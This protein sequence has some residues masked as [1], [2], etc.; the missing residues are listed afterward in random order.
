MRDLFNCRARR[1]LLSG[2]V[3]VLVAAATASPALAGNKFAA[4]APASTA[5]LASTSAADCTMPALS[6][7]FSAYSDT[8]EYAL[9]PGQAFDS[10][11]GTGWTLSGGATIQTAILADGTTGSV[12]DLPSGAEAVSPPM[13]VQS[14]YPNA[15]TMIRDVSGSQAVELGA[16]Y[17]GTSAI[18]SAGRFSGS[19]A[20]WTASN[21]VKTNPGSQSGW[22]L[23][24][25]TLQGSSKAGD[26]QVYNFYVDPRMT[27]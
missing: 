17:A 18:V 27:S 23:V 15:R 11:T 16:Q 7:P 3:S 21:P 12:L 26:E 4:A 5:A 10:F 2:T 13:C 6:E 20:G 25:F 24:V 1:L 9:V 19:G 22:Q 14:D 8:D